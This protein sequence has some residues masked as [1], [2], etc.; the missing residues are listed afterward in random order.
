MRDRVR[1]TE[2]NQPYDLVVESCDQSFLESGDPKELNMIMTCPTQ[3]SGHL[4]QNRLRT[5]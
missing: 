2:S 5:A 4:S 3:L 1:D